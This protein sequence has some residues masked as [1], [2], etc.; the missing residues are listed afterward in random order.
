[1]FHRIFAMEETIRLHGGFAEPFYQAGCGNVPAEIHFTHDYLNSCFHEIAHWCI[2]GRA[3]RLKDDYGYWYSPD[4]RDGMAQEAFFKAESG[5]QALEWA[6]ALASGENFR[7]SCDN[8]GGEVNGEAEFFC[9]LQTTLLDYLRL[10]FPP[11]G[12]KFVNSLMAFYHPEVR[13][14]NISEWLSHEIQ[15]RT[16]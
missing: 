7:P 3:R 2:A 8:L 6:F 10:G 11:R 15:T 12:Q 9:V 5:P 16:N 1:M 4:G 13:P 14:E